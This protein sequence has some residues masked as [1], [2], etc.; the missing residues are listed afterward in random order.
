MKLTDNYDCTELTFELRKKYKV[1][2]I[3]LSNRFRKDEGM[4]IDLDKEKLIQLR[5][6]I[7]EMIGKL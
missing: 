6:E 3:Y 2:R 1:L 7:N 4:A 5:D